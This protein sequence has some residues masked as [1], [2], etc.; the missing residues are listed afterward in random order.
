MDYDVAVIGAGMLG[1]ASA[2]RLAQSGQRV[3]LIE[4][5]EPAAGASG[6][7]FAWLNAVSKEPEAYHRL[8][9][10]GVAEYAGLA[11][12]LGTEIG[13]HG[14]GSLHWAENETG[15]L[16]MQRRVALLTERGYPARWI[17]RDAALRLEP[18]LSIGE[19]VPGAAYYPDEGWLDAPRLVRAF[20]NRAL[21]EGAE[22]LRGAPVDRLHPDD[23]RGTT[24]TTRLGD[25]HARQILICA[26]TG[27][28]A[29]LAPLG[30]SLPVGR[31]PGLLAVTT[32]PA[33]LPGRVIYAP[34]VHF[35]A[36]V[37]GG[38]LLG[39]DDVD[40]HTTEATPPGAPPPFAEPLLQ[41]LRRHF[42]A[43]RSASLAEVRVGVR[44]MPADGHTIAGLVPG[45]GN[46]WVLVTHSGI[47]LG[48]LLGRLIAQ[49]I[50]G[51]PPDP[52]LAPF[53]PDR[54]LAVR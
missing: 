48:P 33:A 8:N 45:L 20:V 41:R 16:A 42:P 7:S 53:R 22:L 5:H 28:P 24:M 10:A 32:P 35:R 6:N 25:A 9:A 27:T 29:L 50:A 18:G 14:G 37:S 39:A 54:F 17:S 4:A 26:G 2:Y 43:A 49:E 36:D 31:V 47:T 19:D 1:A 46:I 15:Q 30:V 3:A 51:A 13:Y 40:E 23:G 52:L 34:G 12:E 21:A 44:P 11:A 38:L